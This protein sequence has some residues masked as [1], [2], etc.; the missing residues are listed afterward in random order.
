MPSYAE[1]PTAQAG[2]VSAGRER[3]EG[4]GMNLRQCWFRFQRATAKLSETHSS[5]PSLSPGCDTTFPMPNWK[6]FRFNQD[7]RGINC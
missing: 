4:E 1:L 7:S 6:A 3:A 2:M 5:D